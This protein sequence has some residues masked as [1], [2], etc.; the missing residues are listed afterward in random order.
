[1]DDSK[2]SRNLRKSSRIHET[3]SAPTSSSTAERNKKEEQTSPALTSPRA[4][5]KRLA[6]L[7]EVPEREKSV[8]PAEDVPPLSA[9]S[10]TATSPDFTDHVCLCQPEPKIPRPRNAFILY[11][12]YHQQGVITLNPGLNNPEISKIIGEKWKAESDEAKKEWQDLAQREK[13]KHQETY[14]DYRYQPRRIS[15]AGSSPLNPTGQ[16]TTV[17]K[18][19]CHKCGGRSI[20]TPTSP[21]LDASGTPTLPPPNISEGLTPTT[22]Y[23][24]VMN[25]LT[26]NSPVAHRRTHGPSGLSNIQVTSSMREDSMMYSP[27]TPNKK[28]R[29]DIPPPLNPLNQVQGRR[30]DGSYYSMQLERRGSLP[31]INV[32]YSPPNSAT[33]PPPRTPR[34]GRMSS[35]VELGPLPQDSSPKSV[36]E[37]LSSLPYPHKIK[38]LGRITPPYKESNPVSALIKGGRGAIIAVE[39]DDLTAV[40]EISQ[41]LNDYL[42]KQR[43]YE[44]RISE[45]PKAPQ[46]DENEDVTFEDYLDLIKEW[47]GKS[48]EMIQYIITPIT[49]PDSPK[50]TTMSDKDS[51]D[52]ASRKDSATPPDS[53][54]AVSVSTVK[55]VIILP[56]FQ[57]HSSIAYASRIPIQ[58]AYSATDHWQWMA[59]LWRGTVGPDLTLYVKSYDAKEGQ[60]GHKPDLDDVNKCLTIFK[61]KK[62]MFLE[63]DLRRVGFEVGEWIKGIK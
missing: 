44:P 4:T 51:I 42:I 45:P 11:R 8:S 18:Y 47:H 36:E 27:L 58:D 24:P 39:G 15:K 2:P 25:G 5:R 59:T 19:R 12:Q 30:P 50:D 37:V 10:T 1:M 60:V 13:A 22:R 33:M 9:T 6:S 32:R 34:D 31:P 23:L 55:P 43:E 61:E 14:P 26:L 48:R 3:R 63:A 57:L 52:T 35:V 46:D 56:T 17:D 21:F 20:K 40:K 49:P 41:W 38:L 29:C 54:S 28:R 7:T 16:H 62:G 53:P